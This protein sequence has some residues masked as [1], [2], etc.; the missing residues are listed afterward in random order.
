L[1]YYNGGAVIEKAARDINNN[2]YFKEQNE[3]GDTGRIKEGLTGRVLTPKE[4]V[5]LQE[6]GGIFTDTH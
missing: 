5:A 3:I 2:L 4:I 6:R 1:K